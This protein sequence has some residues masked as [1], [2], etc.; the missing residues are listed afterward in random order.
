[1]DRSPDVINLSDFGRQLAISAAQNPSL[2]FFIADELRL[3]EHAKVSKEHY[4][5]ERVILVACAAAFSIRAYLEKSALS[6]GIWEGYATFW[7][8]YGESSPERQVTFTRF[9]Q[10]LP[11]Y[12]FA[13]TID[14]EPILRRSQPKDIPEIANEFAQILA[15]NSANS[16]TGRK[17]CDLIAVKYALPIWNSQVTTT[18]ES[19]KRA[20]LPIQER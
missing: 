17:H 9:G 7:R 13:A 5:E 11:I 20:G 15:S 2:R 19:M 3:L 16:D 1:M 4:H 8:E 18:G 12:A 14:I 6:D 10:R